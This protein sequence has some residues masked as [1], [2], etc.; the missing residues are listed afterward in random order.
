M[1]ASASFGLFYLKCSKVNTS[2]I[3]VFLLFLLLMLVI[4]S[5]DH[6]GWARIQNPPASA[7]QV[8]KLKACV[9]TS[10]TVSGAFIL[11]A[12]AL[13]QFQN[14]NKNYSEN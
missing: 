2:Y 10:V 9:I 4:L 12:K 1:L 5:H 6:L 13:S 7:S 3:I 8:P 11:S 14:K